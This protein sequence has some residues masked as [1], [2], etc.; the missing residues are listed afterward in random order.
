M[1]L[2]SL[3]LPRFASFLRDKGIHRAFFIWDDP[4]K[5]LVASHSDLQPVADFIQT[6][7][8]DFARH[9]GI[10]LQV[11]E[12][13][14]CLQAAFIHKTCRGTGQGGTRFWSYPNLADFLSDGLR[15]SRG[16][17][18]KSA[19]AQLWWGGAKGVMSTPEGVDIRSAAVRDSLFTQY[20][21]F[22][23]SLRGLYIAAEDVGST[24]ED[25]ARVHSKTRFV[26]CIPQEIGGSGNPSGATARGVFQGIQAAMH[27]EM[28][29]PIAE[30]RFLVQGLGNV[31]R[32]LIKLLLDGGASVTA[33]DIDPVKVQDALRQFSTYSF[34]ARLSSGDDLDFFSQDCDVFVPC[35]T[36]AILNPRTIPLLKARIV[37]GAANCQLEEEDRDGPAIA[38]RGISY[39]PDFLANRMGVVYCSNEQYGYVKED[40]SIEGHLDQ[41]SS[42]GIYKS[43]IQ[44]LQKAKEVK[45]SPHKIAVKLAETLSNQPHPIF[46]HRGR[47][48]ISDLRSSWIKK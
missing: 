47:L 22:T 27:F 44:V 38:A 2:H 28:G 19:L 26:T 8:R 24:P 5:Q 23:T 10:F 17:T 3:S 29:V 12:G 36:G 41:D 30:R 16:M 25:T 40:P 18:L 14:D 6:E 1:A 42:H 35:A 48:I 20:G 31:A 37:C 13:F 11:P 7:H 43:T 4:T 9:E 32:P 15:L 45:D 39:V 34:N 33:C 46:G 21:E